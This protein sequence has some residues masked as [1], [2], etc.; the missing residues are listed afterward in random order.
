MLFFSF[1]TF[2]IRYQNIYCSSTLSFLY[3]PFL[4]GL[5]KQ[6]CDI[7]KRIL[8]FLV[9]AVMA[10]SM[11]AQKLTSVRSFE[12]LDYVTPHPYDVRKATLGGES[13]TISYNPNTGYG[14]KFRYI[15]RNI[16]I[17]VKFNIQLFNH[18]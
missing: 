3:K 17:S 15:F 6:I 8:L 7:M 16:N 5:G 2:P 18:L 9:G 4:L 11:F 14:I 1:S 13:L 12:Y 10:L